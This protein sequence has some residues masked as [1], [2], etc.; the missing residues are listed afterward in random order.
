KICAYLADKNVYVQDASACADDQY[1]L[2]LRLIAE[3]P[4]SAMF[5]NNMFI[6]PTAEQLKDFDPEWTIICAPGFFANPAEDGTRQENF[7]VLDFTRKM[8]LIGGTGYTGEIKKGIFTVLNFVL[9]HQR[10]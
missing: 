7:A 10:G 3:K 2:S 1:K 8:I 5:A 9:P 6:R 4:W